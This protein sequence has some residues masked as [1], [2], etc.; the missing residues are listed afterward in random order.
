ME[1][2]LYTVQ[3]AAEIL[4]MHT[5]TI[6]AW[7]RSGKLKSVRPGRKWLIPAEEIESFINS[8]DRPESR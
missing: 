5:Q 1:K 2:K 4:R 7:L 8:L 3:E 6:Y